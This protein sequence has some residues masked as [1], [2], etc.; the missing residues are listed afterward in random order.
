MPSVSAFWR[1][2]PTDR[3]VNFA[4]LAIGVLAFECARNSFT[5]ALV[6]SRRTVFF[7]FFATYCSLI[8]EAAYY[9]KY[10]E[11]QAS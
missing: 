1:S 7:A 2:A 10:P 9:H 4:T 8:C 3:F 6:Y 5:S 11:P